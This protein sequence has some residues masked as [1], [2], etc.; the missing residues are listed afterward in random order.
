VAVTSSGRVETPRLH[1]FEALI[2]GPDSDPSSRVAGRLRAA[3]S[4]GLVKDGEALPSEPVLAE[5]LGTSLFTLRE[6]LAVLRD[7]RLIETRRGRGGGSF[8]RAG[9]ALDS[10]TVGHRLSQMSSAEVRDIGEWRQVL[11]GAEARLAAERASQRNITRLREYVT[12]VVNAGD[13]AETLSAYGRV[14]L[15][16]A[17]AAQSVR[18]SREEILLISSHG[19]MFAHAL[20]TQ[21][22]RGDFARTYGKVIDSVERGDGP[23]ARR[24]AESHAANLATGALQARLNGLRAGKGTDAGHQS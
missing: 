7:E 12:R 14:H 1:P 23:R 17:A 15:E 5:Q 10:Q 6:A 22:A 4:L 16:L 3:I 24:L 9:Q 21:R 8:V 20:S 11:A 19:W 18:M 13:V 2:E